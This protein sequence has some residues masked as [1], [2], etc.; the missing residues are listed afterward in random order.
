MKNT[1]DCS[2]NTCDKEMVG[3]Y[4]P[5]SNKFVKANVCAKDLK[6]IISEPYVFVK[7]ELEYNFLK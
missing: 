6:S 7:E 1:F 5:Q 3:L 4:L 2:C